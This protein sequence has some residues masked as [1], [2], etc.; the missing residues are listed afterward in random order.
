MSLAE[1][2]STHLTKSL[3]ID[4]HDVYGIAHLDM[5][6]YVLCRSPNVLILYSDQPPFIKIKDID[7]SRHVK[8]PQDVAACNT[9]KC[10]YVTDIGN[11]CVW[12][13]EPGYPL[14][15]AKW[16]S[17]VT[18]PHT[19]SVNAR[20]GQVTTFGNQSKSLHVYAPTGDLAYTVSLPGDARFPQHA[21]ETSKG[22]FVVSYGDLKGKKHGVCEV[23]P[24][25]K[26]TCRYEHKLEKLNHPTHLA[27][28]ADDKVF[29][30]D[31]DNSRVVQLDARL[32]FE[33]SLPSDERDRLEKPFRLCYASSS[34][35][36]QKRLLVEH[37]INTVDIFNVS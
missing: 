16:A 35:P 37:R 30:A 15:I 29:V 9:S 2:I 6:Y 21:V 20:N 14:R 13:V 11:S 8:L 33:Q 7:I 26:T 34:K 12:K 36:V 27:I 32:K 4:K 3:V 10:L 5:R 23:S 31:H 1:A 25:G 18:A 19:V 17:D 22:N 28:D 24:K